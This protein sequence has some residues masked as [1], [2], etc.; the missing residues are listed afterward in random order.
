MSALAKDPDARPQNALAFA[1]ALRASSE[2]LSVLCR[3]GFALYSEYFPKVIALSLLAHIPTILFALLLILLPPEHH[4]KG[5]GSQLQG[6]IVS[7]KSLANFVAGSTIAGVVAI[8]VNQVVVA[9]LRPVSLRSAFTVL[10][11]RWLPF[12]KTGIGATARIY[13]GFLAAIFP[14]VLMM[15]RYS[16]WAPVALLE[17]LQGKA[18]LRRARALAA[19][20]W[21]TSLFAVLFQLGPAALVPWLILR[22]LSPAGTHA[23]TL[24]QRATSE[25]SSLSS[26]LFMPLVSIVLA[27]VYLKMRQLAGESPVPL[28]TDTLKI[29]TPE[30]PTQLLR[31]E[32]TW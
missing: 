15:T 9:P 3:R 2:T 20:S 16:L 10:R 22:I 21:G 25:L 11:Q 8:V 19:R 17:G 12:L 18:A 24:A 7:L 14:G 28:E 4:W 29:G 30:H 13:I 23:E 1:H 5:R 26:I 31:E 27:L 32:G 6:I